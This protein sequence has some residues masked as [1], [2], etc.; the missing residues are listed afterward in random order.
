MSGIQSIE[1]AFSILEAIATQPTGLGVTDIAVQVGLPKSTV[2]RILTTL[3]AVNAIERLPNNDGFQLGQTMRTLALNIPYSQ[4]LITITRPYLLEL[5]EYTG[6]AVGL[7]VPDGDQVHYVDQLQSQ[8]QVQ[9][10]DW[11]G[12]RFPM[13]VVS[14]GKLFMACWSQEV[15]DDYL[16]RPLTKPTERTLTDPTALRQRLAQVRQQGY[17]WTYEEFAE[18]LNAVSA[19][20]YDQSSRIIAA[21]NIYGPAFRFPVAEHHAEI[22]Q[23]L[24][25]ITQKISDRLRRYDSP[26]N[27]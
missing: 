22:T 3:T 23:L 13:H 10:R 15:L 26:T 14:A 25:T 9:V 21:I 18:G 8:H 6:E 17:D 19:P 1:R 2:S 4:Q 16:E 7:C 24:L 11:T 20:I 27:R 5:A 12:V